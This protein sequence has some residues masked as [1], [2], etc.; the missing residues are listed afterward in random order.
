VV[1]WSPF[2]SRW[3]PGDWN[4][5][6]SLIFVVLVVTTGVSTVEGAIQAGI[7][8][9]VVTQLLT[10]LPSR[11]GGSSLVIVLFAFGA[12]QYARHPEGRSRVPEATV[13]RSLRATPLSQGVLPIQSAA[14]TRGD[15]WLIAPLLS[16]RRRGKSFG[17]ID[18]VHDITFESAPARASAWSARTVPA[19]RPSSTA[20][21]G[22]CATTRGDILF[23]GR[24]LSGL[25]TY[26]RARLGI[27]RT[28]QKVEVFTDMTVRDHL[29]V[30]ERARRGEGGSG[31]TCST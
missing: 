21:A 7:G 2:K 15:R 16:L 13:D 26:K 14:G 4:Y 17:G 5:D 18:A 19:R 12:L 29:M 24:P 6:Y 25:P 27:G 11:F 8:F 28:Y 1:C 22:N 31:R 30:A 20:C 10:Y 23:E 9:F 3:P